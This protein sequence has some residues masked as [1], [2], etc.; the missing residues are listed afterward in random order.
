MTV[1][2]VNDVETVEVPDFPGF[3]DHVAV[4]FFKIAPNTLHIDPSALCSVFMGGVK[5]RDLS[6]SEP[7]R[8]SHRVENR[9]KDPTLP[10]TD[11]TEALLDILAENLDGVRPTGRIS[12]AGEAPFSFLTATKNK[13]I[14]PRSLAGIALS[15]ALHAAAGSSIQISHPIHRLPILLFLKPIYSMV[16]TS[17]LQYIEHNSLTKK[18]N[19]IGRTSQEHQ[20]RQDMY[21][22]TS[23][24]LLAPKTQSHS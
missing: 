1:H 16:H 23:G 10:E 11:S 22:I 14:K 7:E 18:L 17:L 4:V 6:R 15:C 24:T 19:M 5:D 21:Q 8:A 2:E 13:R 20:F 9:T 12:P 3:C